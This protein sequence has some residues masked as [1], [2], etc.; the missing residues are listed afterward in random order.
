[1]M[2]TN[3]PEI[4]NL[5]EVASV[6]RIRRAVAWR[7]AKSGKLPF[8]RVGKTYRMMRANLEKF[9]IEGGKP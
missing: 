9:I 7:L 6:L 1:M 4:M 8:F 2:T 5:T 3:M